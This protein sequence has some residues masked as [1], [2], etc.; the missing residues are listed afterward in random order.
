MENLSNFIN[1]QLDDVRNQIDNAKQFMI[2][3]DIIDVNNGMYRNYKHYLEEKQSLQFAVNQEREK[4]F[5]ESNGIVK[6]FFDP[7]VL[8]E[9]AFEMALKYNFS[10]CEEK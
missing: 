8:N 3:K 1:K 10:I 7:F 2:I 5:L 9:E 6:I 4:Q